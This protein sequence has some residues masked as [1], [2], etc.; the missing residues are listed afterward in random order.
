MAEGSQR[1]AGRRQARWTMAVER[2]LARKMRA[3]V[4]VRGR[5]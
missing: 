4:R 3:M 2:R 1:R 5:I